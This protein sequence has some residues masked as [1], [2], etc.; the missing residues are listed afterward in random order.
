[1]GSGQLWSVVVSYCILINNHVLL[2]VCSKENA[3]V[4]PFLRTCCGMGFVVSQV[5][6]FQEFRG[7]MGFMVPQVS[8]TVV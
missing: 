8:Y 4:L 1:M 2:L 7:F 6:W 5:L 3:E